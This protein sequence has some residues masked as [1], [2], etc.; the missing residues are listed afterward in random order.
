MHA[1]E[2][3]RPHAVYPARHGLLRWETSEQ[4][5]DF[6]WQTG[7]ADPDD[8]RVLA[9]HDFGNWGQFDC[10][11]PEFILRMLTDIQFEFPTS[12]MAVHYFAPID[13]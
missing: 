12:H 1:A 8:W 13:R 2:L 5:I 4:E 6:V 9:Q 3:W 7:A 10:G 11:V